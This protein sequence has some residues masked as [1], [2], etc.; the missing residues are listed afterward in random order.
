MSIKILLYEEYGNIYLFSL[1]YDFL[2]FKEQVKV[3]YN[4]P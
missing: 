3:T 2:P 1:Y 4:L